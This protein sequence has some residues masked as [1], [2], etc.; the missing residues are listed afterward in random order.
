MYKELWYDSITA[1]QSATK[2]PAT[3]TPL[4]YFDSSIRR[5]KS[6]KILEVILPQSYY[7]FVP[8]PQTFTGTKPADTIING[9]TIFAP[10]GHQIWKLEAYNPSNSNKFDILVPVGG[11]SAQELVAYFTNV[12]FN[13]LVGLPAF[14]V[15]FL[16]MTGVALNTATVTF[17]A[18]PETLTWSFATATDVGLNTAAIFGI[19][20]QEQPAGF[21]LPYAAYS[22]G[23]PKFSNPFVN[24]NFNIVYTSK[25]CNAN[26]YNYITLQSESLGTFFSI[27][28]N[29][30]SEANVFGYNV[31]S[32]TNALTV[33]PLTSNYT[34]VATWEDPNPS[35]QFTDIKA[36]I[37]RMDF[38]LTLGPYINEPL[39]LNGQSFQ[40]K[41]AIETEDDGGDML[42][43]QRYW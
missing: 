17:N 26:P 33:I 29:S 4:F 8:Y 16:A 42:K 15:A 43:R 40:V 32:V 14:K 13:P 11:G 10:R 23:F 39:D 38:Y 34:S 2:Y 25:F 36:T 27:N 28:P 37:D 9:E 18:G 19:R 5:I 6:A 35:S 1:T 30:N 20:F 3:D 24:K 21:G 31:K 22:L 12:T 41:I 7:S